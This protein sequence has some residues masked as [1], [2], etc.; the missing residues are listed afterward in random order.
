MTVNIYAIV[1]GSTIAISYFLIIFLIRKRRSSKYRLFFQVLSLDLRAKLGEAVI[2][3]SS[4]QES[5]NMFYPELPKFDEIFHI[6][7]KDLVSRVKWTVDPKKHG[8]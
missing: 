8:L 7:V 1:L 6:P 4:L 5:L 2:L 3:P